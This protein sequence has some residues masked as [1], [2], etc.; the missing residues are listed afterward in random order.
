M[1]FFLEVILTILFLPI[2]LIAWPLGSLFDFISDET[3]FGA[4][5]GGRDE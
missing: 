3:S 4:R 1:R 2:L 5:V